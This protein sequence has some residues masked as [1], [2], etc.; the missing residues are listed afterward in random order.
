[1]TT[2]QHAP[3][4]EQT[5]TENPEFYANSNIAHDHQVY[6]IE[7]LAAD[8]DRTVESAMHRIAPW[9]GKVVL[10]IGAGTGFHIPRFAA[11]AAHVVAV[12][13][14]PQLRHV[15]MQR[16]VHEGISN[17]SI[18]GA[19]AADIPL[20]DYSVDIVHARF[21]YFFGPGADSGL[22]ELERVI[23]PCGTAFIIDNDLRSGTF[24]TWV[25]R[26]YDNPDAIVAEYETF[27]RKHGFTIDRLASRWAFERREDFERVIRLEF[28]EDQA[29]RII[30]EHEGLEVDYN[31]LLIHRQY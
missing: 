28:P 27:W 21:A 6:E 15:M 17:V 9:E 25:L 19:S 23:A 22:R 30:D 26:G 29:A 1:M 5:W 31:L 11:T 2:G 8:P 10:D 7:N 24:A 12:D 14:D 16:M 20:R 13:P 4:T 18:I 3:L